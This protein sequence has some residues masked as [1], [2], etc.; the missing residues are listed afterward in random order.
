MQEMG[1]YTRV[2]PDNRIKKLMAFN[3]RLRKTPAS[4]DVFTEWQMQLDN[5]LVEVPGRE[6]RNELI[7]FGNN[8]KYVL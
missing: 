6:L 4:N 5:N 7:V 3:E 2:G 1:G 8:V